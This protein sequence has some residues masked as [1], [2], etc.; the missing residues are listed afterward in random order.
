MSPYPLSL[1]SCIWQSP[2]T[3]PMCPLGKSP[4]RHPCLRSLCRIWW[5]RQELTCYLSVSSPPTPHPK[6]SYR[7]GWRL[8]GCDGK[9]VVWGQDRSPGILLWGRGE[10]SVHG[11]AL[12]LVYSGRL[13]PTSPAQKCGGRAS[14]VR[15]GSSKFPQGKMTEDVLCWQG[16][17]LAYTRF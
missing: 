1:C 16:A 9:H 15:A 5:W 2:Q 11:A 6:V 3:T 8:A 10:L 14:G 4:W 12:A 17:C 7:E 13:S